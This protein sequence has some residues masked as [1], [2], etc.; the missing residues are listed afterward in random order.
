MLSYGGTD[1]NVGA[2]YVNQ[3]LSEVFRVLKRG[4]KFLFLEHGLSPEPRVQKWQHRLNW[5]E[6][7]WADK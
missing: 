3:A 2:P 5:L 6:M 7:R 4:G 1:I